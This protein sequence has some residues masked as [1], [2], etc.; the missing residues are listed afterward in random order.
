MSKEEL[1]ARARGISERHAQRAADIHVLAI[2]RLATRQ[3]AAEARAA[4][5]AAMADDLADE[6][7]SVA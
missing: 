3:A 2:N 1:E 7:D 5:E 4:R 6:P